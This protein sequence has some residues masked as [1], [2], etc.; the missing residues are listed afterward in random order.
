MLAH[1]GD[2]APDARREIAD[3]YLAV[4]QGFEH[5]Q[6]FRIRQ[7]S[8]DDGRALIRI[9]GC[10]GGCCCHVQVSIAVLAQLRK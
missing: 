2:L 6:A 4:R 8:A 10:A 7:G 5:A 9:L 1:V 3:R